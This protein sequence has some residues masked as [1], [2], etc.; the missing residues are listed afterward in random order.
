VTLTESIAKEIEAIG[1]ASKTQFI[2]TKVDMASQGIAK[3]RVL[4]IIIK[5]VIYSRPSPP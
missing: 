5:L 4:S 2:I 3:E 1:E